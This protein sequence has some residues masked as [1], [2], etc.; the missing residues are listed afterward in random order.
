MMALMW[1][2]WDLFSRLKEIKQIR[3]TEMEVRLSQLMLKF[4][5]KVNNTKKLDVLEITYGKKPT[6]NPIDFSKNYLVYG[7]HK[8]IRTILNELADAIREFAGQ[9]DPD[10]IKVDLVYCYPEECPHSNVDERKNIDAGKWKIIK[11]VTDAPTD[12]TH[13][14]LLSDQNSFYFYFREHSYA[15]KN[16]KNS[17]ADNIPYKLVQKDNEKNGVGSVVGQKF[18]IVNDVP[19]KEQVRAILTI[20]TY[21]WTLWNK[22]YGVSLEEFKNLFVKYVINGCK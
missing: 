4:N 5:N 18:S 8:Q 14:D 9:S 2:I 17:T 13:I 15:F 22:S 20:T 16:D 12:M 11:A 7:V 6:F 10:T 21:G 3:L 19:V 1:F